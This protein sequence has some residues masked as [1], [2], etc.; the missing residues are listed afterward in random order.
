[1]KLNLL[2]SLSIKSKLSLIIF[3]FVCLPL[4]IFGY[5]WYDKST[6][7]IEENA[8]QYSQNLLNQTNKY[9]DFYLDELERST[10][11]LQSNPNVQEFLRIIP[12]EK[13]K[14]FVYISVYK[15]G[16]FPL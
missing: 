13:Y 12:T 9:L 1:M 14:R 6:H 8:I 7:T 16:I 11:P 3:L 2:K 10:V 15:K 5:V 4:L